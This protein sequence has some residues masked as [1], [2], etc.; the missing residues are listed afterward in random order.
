MCS[1]II[2]RTRYLGLCGPFNG[3]WYSSPVSTLSLCKQQVLHVYYFVRERK[4]YT[5]AGTYYFLRERKIYTSAG[6]SCVLFCEGTQSPFSK[7]RPFLVEQGTIEIIVPVVGP[8][9]T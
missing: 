4:I 7:A 3:K 8:I 9:D 5:S 1:S 6:T 2:I